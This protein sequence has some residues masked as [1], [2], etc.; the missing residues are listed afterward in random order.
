MSVSMGPCLCLSLNLCVSMSE[1]VDVACTCLYNSVRVSVC[2]FLHVLYSL[3]FVELRINTL[4]FHHFHF[5]CVGTG[6][7]VCGYGECI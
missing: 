4:Y 3:L 7:Y 6:E 2:K 1:S 5:Q